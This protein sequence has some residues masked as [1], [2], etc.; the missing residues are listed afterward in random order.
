V[1]HTGGFVSNL[2]LSPYYLINNGQLLKDT[3][4]QVAL[5]IPD[6]V[7][8]FHF[9]VLLPAADYATVADLLTSIPS[10]L[11]GKNGESIGTAFP[12]VG[13]TDVRTSVNGTVYKWH[14]EADQSTSSTAVKAFVARLNFQY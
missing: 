6:D 9:N 12:D 4:V 3:T 7:N 14:F 10:E 8:A 13:Y 2:A 5:G 1:G 11:L